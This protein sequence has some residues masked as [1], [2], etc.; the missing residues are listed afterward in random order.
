MSD[1]AILVLP[2]YPFIVDR[3]KKSDSMIYAVLFDLKIDSRSSHSRL[4]AVP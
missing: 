4:D 2:P 1:R 3:M